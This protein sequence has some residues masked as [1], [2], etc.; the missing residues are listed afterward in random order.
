MK[1]PTLIVR[2]VSLYL[3][4]NCTLTLLQ[5]H[6][7]SSMG[8]LGGAQQSTI[9]DLQLYAILGLIVGI[10]G[11]AFAGPAARLLTFDA[12]PRVSQSEVTERL[13]ARK[14]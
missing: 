5:I 8:P 12:K 14:N 7:L 4:V 9:S 3:V 10:T 11:T 1:T 2:L 13:L 6:S